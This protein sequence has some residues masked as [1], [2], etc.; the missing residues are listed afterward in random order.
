MHRHKQSGFTLIEV[1]VFTAIAS[2]V[3]VVLVSVSITIMRQSQIAM[4]KVY[5]AHFSFEATEWLRL[6]KELGWQPFYD[7][8]Q[9]PTGKIFCAN[10]GLA[11]TDTLSSALTVVSDSASCPFAGVSY[12]D[13]TNVSPRIYRRTI[14]FDPATDNTQAVKAVVLVEWKE[15]NG[16]LYSV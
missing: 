14:T 8:V 2:I 5:A 6:Q 7:T 15:S 13:T 11:I 1:L 3:L 4:H 10:T 9:S 12:A 16:T